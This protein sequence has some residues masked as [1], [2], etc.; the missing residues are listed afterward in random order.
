MYSVRA[1]VNTTGGG[2]AGN[3]FF[4]LW[5]PH[6]DQIVK[7]RRIVVCMDS[8]S[9]N[10][11]GNFARSSARGTPASTITPDI[12]NDSRRAVAPPSGVLLDLGVYTVQPTIDAG[13]LGIILAPSSDNAAGARGEILMQDLGGGLYIPPGTG[14]CF[15]SRT[16]G[17][18]TFELG[19][20]W[21]EDL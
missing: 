17:A 5:N 13:D 14:L 2:G 6:A 3:A 19:F 21:S 9:A 4:G 16:S 7:V 1:V 18:P 8:G 12:S 11:V 20:T 15:V 10:F